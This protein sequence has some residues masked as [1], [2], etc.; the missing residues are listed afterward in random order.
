MLTAAYSQGKSL[1]A[2]VDGTAEH[3][4]PHQ[5]HVGGVLTLDEAAQVMLDDVT[6]RLTSDGHAYNVVQ[7]ETESSLLCQ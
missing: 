6:G 5:L 2:V 4:V 7:N 1:S 3:L